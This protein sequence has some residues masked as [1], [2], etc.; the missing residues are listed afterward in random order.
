[1]E[2]I[3]KSQRCAAEEF[4]GFF[5]VKLQRIDLSEVPLE[6]AYMRLHTYLYLDR[7]SRQ[8]TSLCLVPQ[9]E[10]MRSDATTTRNCNY[11]WSETTENGTATS[12]VTA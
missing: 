9:R 6:C 10:K 4:D 7:L 12:H 8:A 5:A 1:M 11:D 2:V 3:G